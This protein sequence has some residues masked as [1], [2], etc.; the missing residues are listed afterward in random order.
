MSYHTLGYVS[1]LT[2]SIMFLAFVHNLHHYYQQNSRCLQHQWGTLLS[3]TSRYAVYFL[4]LLHIHL[5]KTSRGAPVE[6]CLS[7]FARTRCSDISTAH[8][9]HQDS[10]ELPSCSTKNTEKQDQSEDSTNPTPLMLQI[11]LMSN[12]IPSHS[13]SRWQ[14]MA[15][16]VTCQQG[17]H[18]CA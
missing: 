11:K 18:C 12:R 8:S 9:P 15:C 13:S 1:V 5:E 7:S 4:I 3:P 6:G 14:L 2:V 17:T 10:T 16:G